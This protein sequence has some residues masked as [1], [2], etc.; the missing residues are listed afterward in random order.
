MSQVELP[1][2][3]REASTLLGA[4]DQQRRHVLGILEGLP[5]EALHQAVLPSG[6]TPAGLV[7]HLAF[8]VEHF[9][10]CLV[11]SGGEEG[12]HVEEPPDAWQVAPGT[13]GDAILDL[14]RGEVERANDVIRATPMDAPPAWWPE[15]LFGSWRL[16]DMRQILVHVI[17]ETA[18]HAGHLD[19]ARELVDGRTWLVLNR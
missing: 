18:C 12:E 15:E 17:T 4:L 8:D 5:E 10:F 6:W 2:L 9:W 13:S 19:A 11:V 16:D 3:G 1:D 14:Y 7:Q